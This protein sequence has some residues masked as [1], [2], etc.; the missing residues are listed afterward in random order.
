MADCMG[1]DQAARAGDHN[2]RHCKR[3]SGTCWIHQ[4]TPVTLRTQFVRQIINQFSTEERRELHEAAEAGL[5]PFT[6][7]VDR[8][9]LDQMPN[10]VTNRELDAALVLIKYRQREAN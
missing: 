4:F 3:G 2:C 9:P 7:G 8:I 1:R 10:S 5:L 6:T